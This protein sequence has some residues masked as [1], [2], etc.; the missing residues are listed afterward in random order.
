MGKLLISLL[1]LQI[2]LSACSNQNNVNNTTSL[3]I[4]TTAPQNTQKPNL[5]QVVVTTSVL[6]DLTKQVAGNTVDI[7][8]LIPSDTNPRNYQPQLKDRQ[9]ID[10]AKLVLYN[11][12]NLEPGVFN[13]IKASKNPA[14]RIAVA[15]VAV[16]KPRLSIQ[17]GNKKQINPYLWHNP[18]NT[19]AMIDVISNNLKKVAPQNAK[20][21]TTNSNK[22]KN[23]IAALD[24]WIKS[25]IASI[26]S[27]QR[28]LITNNVQMGYYT[29]AY[30]LTYETAFL[31]INYSD[32]PNS[33]QLKP[34]ITNI[35]K[36]RVPSI[37]ISNAANPQ[38]V[39][40][41]AKQA[42][43]RVSERSL[44]TNNLGAKGSESDNY[45]KMMIANTRTIVEGLG[46]TYLIFRPGTAKGANS[47]S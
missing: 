31:T 5:P 41:V 36:T 45:Q 15:Q 47:N 35:R 1:T 26:P 34:L 24:K 6:C 19:T 3:T 8:C 42:D 43:V 44:L 7:N 38:V 4:R 37:F 14:P 32:N 12:Y 20:L 33:P 11:G 17:Q 30:G 10:R 46:G 39:Q 27:Y 23:Q 29:T 21:Y 40:S 9:A 18:K 22:L 28:T 13:T 16:P 2:L 25:R